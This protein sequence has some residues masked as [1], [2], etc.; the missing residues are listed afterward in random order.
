[1]CKV[2]LHKQIYMSTFDQALL[3]RGKDYDADVPTRT[4]RII[5]V[6]GLPSRTVTWWPRNNSLCFKYKDG[7]ARTRRWFF[8]VSR[9]GNDECYRKA[10]ADLKEF[11]RG[12][13]ADPESESDDGN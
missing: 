3:I 8:H 2:S 11:A 6:E 10:L 13:V 9:M 5:N 7:D 4:K 1:M 12:V